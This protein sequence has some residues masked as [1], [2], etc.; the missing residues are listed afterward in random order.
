MKKIYLFFPFLLL[1]CFS[2]AQFVVNSPGNDYTLT[3]YN[4]AITMTATPPTGF[5]Y[6]WTNGAISYYGPNHNITLPGTWTVIGKDNNTSATSTQTFLV[7]QDISTPSVIITPTVNNITCAGGSGCFTATSTGSITN[8]FTKINSSGSKMYASVNGGTFNV[9]CA[10]SPGVYWFESINP[11]NGCSGTKSVQV[12]ASVGVPI[13]TVTSSSNFSLGCNTASCTTMSIGNVITSPVPNVPVNYAFVPPPG[14]ATPVYSSTFTNGPV[15]SQGPWLVYTKDLTN[16]CIAI[17]TICIVQN[18]NVPNAY[19]AADAI[20]V[21]CKSPNAHLIG[22]TNSANTTISWLVPPSVPVNTPSITATVQSAYPNAQYSVTGLGNFTVVVTNSLT[23]CAGTETIHLIQDLRVP[24]FTITASPNQSITCNNTSV[25][26]TA[27]FTPFVNS[28]LFPSV[29]WQTPLPPTFTGTTHTTTTV[30]N[31]ATAYSWVNGCS[32]VQTFTAPTEYLESIVDKTIS[33]SC[34]VQTVD[35]TP[36]YSNGTVG[37]SFAWSGAI[38]SASNLSSVV[39][40]SLGV[41]VCVL[42]STATNCSKTIS[43]TVVCSTGLHKNVF[44]ENALLLSP[45]PFVD[46]L[47]INSKNSS[48]VVSSLEILN[49]LGQKVFETND[50]KVNEAINLNLPKGL[51]F[52]SMEIDGQKQVYKVIRE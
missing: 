39:G 10:G 21:N 8:W 40:T 50:Q 34:P 46:Q 4:S 29:E 31:T 26:L 28:A 2:K 33:V 17:N 6:T 36:D 25:T 37:L 23:Q 19:L 22:L 42:T 16:N 52:V 30:V 27:S 1:A 15:C 44:D 48:L 47:S 13:F 49:T 38:S 32:Y 45:N 24:Y 9:M 5:S 18:T 43:V 20:L 7:T 51:Y 12:T 11:A 35:V 41:Y 3:C 14:T